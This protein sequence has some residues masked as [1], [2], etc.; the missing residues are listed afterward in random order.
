MSAQ[1]KYISREEFRK[2]KQFIKIDKDISTCLKLINKLIKYNEECRNEVA[3]KLEIANYIEDYRS[4]QFG[5]YENTLKS[6]YFSCLSLKN[7]YDIN[8]QMNFVGIGGTIGDTLENQRSYITF[9]AIVKMH[10]IFE[11]TRKVYEKKIPKKSYFKYLRQKYGDLTEA[12]D[13]LHKFRNTIHSNGKWQP[14]NGKDNLIYHAR[15]GR[16]II[17]PGEPFR[18]DHWLL[19]RIIKDCLHLNKLMALDNEGDR[20]RNTRIIVNGQKLV[21]VKTEVKDWDSLFKKAKTE[22]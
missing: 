20:I 3:S 9:S 18:Y 13:V 12:I 6:I 7:I 16:Q 2:S 1:I 4:D 21:A 22:I 10:G 19:Y 8:A 17:K 5:Y 11:Y 15:E 14:K